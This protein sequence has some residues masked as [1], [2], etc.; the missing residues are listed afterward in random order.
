MPKSFP[1]LRETEV[2][3]STA[4]L[5]KQLAQDDSLGQLRKALRAC[6]AHEEAPKRVEVRPLTELSSASPF[7]A[8]SQRGIGGLTASVGSG[9]Q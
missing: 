8:S 1:L 9:K 7:S 6:A 2:R 4:D 3:N 5:S